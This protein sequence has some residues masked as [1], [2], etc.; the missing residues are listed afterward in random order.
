M[1]PLL[2]HVFSHLKRTLPVLAVAA[3]VVI[4]PAQAQNKI[5]HAT[6]FYS[7]TDWGDFIADA[8][9][10]FK[11]EGLEVETIPARS[12]S[13]AVQELAAGSVQI[14]SSGMPD[15][16]RGIAE[17]APMKMFMSQIGTPP[18]TVYGN[19]SIKSVKQLKGKKVI[20][21]GPQDV[22]R[23]YIERLFKKEGLTPGSYDYIYAGATSDRFAALVAGG[24][25]AAILLPPYSFK[26]R[27]LGYTDL[28][29]VQTVLS[30][31]PF[32]IYSYNSDWAKT[33]HTEL[34]DF[35]VA[36]L[37]G[38][39]WLY[40]PAHR[41]EAAQILSKYTKT[42]MPDSLEN[43]DFYIKDLK[44]IS[45]NGVISEASYDKMMNVLVG[46]GEMKSPIPAFS[47]YYD[48]SVLADANKLLKK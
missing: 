35:A 31:F 33:H 27:Q 10:F 18:Y 46:W 11:Q 16:L 22:T 7:S 23:Y 26:A 14:A 42:S 24:A 44:A 17:G 2:H 5:E 45:R 25:D 6:V 4:A 43:Y 38:K 20:I 29:N 47:S 37:K 1:K 3:V 28:G 32:T 41:Q 36:M 34:V 30:D 9:G 13:K 40:D 12:S 39:A 8:K 19:P 48:A 21:G 15:H